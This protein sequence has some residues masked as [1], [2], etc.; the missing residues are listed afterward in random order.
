[1]TK[2]YSSEIE[3]QMRE[4]YDRLPEK[5]KRLYAGVEALKLPHGGISYIAKLF[6]CSR[7]AIY[8][9]IKELNEETT[10]AQDRNRHKGG[11]R[12]SVLEQQPAINDVFLVLIKE[13]TAGDP[14]DDKKSGQI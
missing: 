8:R 10:L 1:M 5:N 7:E 6:A 3:S 14:M 2:P 11:G 12:Q 13:H 4:F 9:G